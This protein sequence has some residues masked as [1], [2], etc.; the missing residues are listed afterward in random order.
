MC[1]QGGD[2]RPD[3]AGGLGSKSTKEECWFVNDGSKNFFDWPGILFS[4]EGPFL[5][6]ARPS[7]FSRADSHYQIPP[8]FFFRVSTF[9]LV[10]YLP[11]KANNL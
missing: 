9:V 4:I 7:N 2:G 8:R 11:F 1:E 5:M 6:E 10:R 3:G